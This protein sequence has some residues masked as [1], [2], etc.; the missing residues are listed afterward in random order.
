MIV[1]M[2]LFTV[3][4]VNQLVEWKNGEATRDPLAMAL[5]QWLT[6]APSM[7]NSGATHM[8]P[9]NVLLWHHPWLTMAPFIVSHDDGEIYRDCRQEGWHSTWHG[10]IHGQPWYDPQM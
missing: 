7:P 4:P 1:I 9:C 5:Y 2:E 3:I 8:S 6:M 10:A